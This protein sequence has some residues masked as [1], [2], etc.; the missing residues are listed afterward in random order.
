AAAGI[1]SKMGELRSVGSPAPYQ[2]GVREQFAIFNGHYEGAE[3]SDK[4]QFS[5]VMERL[6]YLAPRTVVVQAGS[7]DNEIHDRIAALHANDPRR[8]LKPLCGSRAKGTMQAEDPDQALVFARQERRPYLVQTVENTNHEWRYAVH[9][10]PQQVRDGAPHRWRMALRKIRPSVTGDGMTPLDTLVQ[11]N[12]D[13]PWF[14]RTKYRLHR[15]SDTGRIPED[16]EHVEL[17]VGGNIGARLPDSTEQ[18]NL[19][20]FMR[21]VTS[22][23]ERQIGAPLATI[24][25]D[26]GVKH[27]DTLAG[28]YDHGKLRQELVF[29]EYQVPFGFF[30]YLPAIPRS[31]HHG[32]RR[33][34][35][36]M[37]NVGYRPAV[38]LA[39]MNSMFV[40]GKVA[41]KL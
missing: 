34:I 16:G 7:D 31:D 25:F 33:A 24:C 22:E 1:S 21:V 4:A 39:F 6:G 8:F 5:E 14:S 26:I 3:L 30:S 38:M 13:M 36:S 20:Q 27:A 2:R 29:Y 12:P 10:D 40:S 19:D 17:A 15:G 35:S 11:N 23:L 41:S 32:I 9:R 18:A 28:P 37:A